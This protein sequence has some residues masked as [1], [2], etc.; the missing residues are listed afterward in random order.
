MNSFPAFG[1]LLGSRARL[2]ELCALLEANSGLPG[3]RANLELVYSF[4]T[5]V[6]G[7]HLEEWQWDFLVG[8]AATSPTKAPV[9]SS[10]E[11]LPVCAIV[12]LGALYGTGLPRPR[13]RMALAALAVAASDPRWRVRE[14]AAM[15]LQQIGERDLAL[16]RGIVTDWLPG[17]RPLVLRAI[18]AGLAHP[19][20]LK[21][22]DFAL[23]SLENA[24]S[25]LSTVSRASA[26][27]RKSDDFRV[28]RQGMSYALSVFVAHVP[29]EGFALMRKLAAVRDPDIARIMRENLKKKRLSDAFHDDVK[30]VSLILDEA[31]G[32]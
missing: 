3:P 7:M 31:N 25:I 1:I 29:V 28:L 11:Y 22:K 21:D 17:G 20:I 26:E 5:S 10:R 19:P 18:A 14:A 13:R 24:R 8:L 32:R 9:N 23:F 27:E 12:A 4:A 6:A 2:Q 16:L 15:G 30:Q